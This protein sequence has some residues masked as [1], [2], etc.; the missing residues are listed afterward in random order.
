MTRIFAHIDTDLALR[1]AWRG[2]KIACGGAKA[3][4]L[5][6]ENDTQWRDSVKKIGPER[7]CLR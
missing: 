5:P 2:L 7:I 1:R 4:K 6:L 3:V